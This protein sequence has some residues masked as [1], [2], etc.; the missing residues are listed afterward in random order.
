[1]MT[2][3]GDSQV[4]GT[5]EVVK[6][7]IRSLR[8]GRGIN[9]PSLDQRV[10]RYL[11]EL[12]AHAGDA[13]VGRHALARELSVLAGHLPDDLRTAVASSLGLA[14][15]TKQMAHFDDRVAWLA[16]HLQCGPRTAQ[17]RIDEAEQLLAE[18]TTREL[19]RRRSRTP[20]TADGWYIEEFR[21][22]YR[23]DTAT[24]ES[25]EHRRIVATHDG[26]S[27]VRAW[28]NV[29]GTSEQPRTTVTGE[30]LYGGRLLRREHPSQNRF[31]FVVRL[32]EP[33]R[34][35]QHHEYG[36]ILRPPQGQRLRPHYVF[37]PECDCRMFDLRVRFDPNRLPHW[38]R[39]VDGEPVRVF[40]SAQPPSDRLSPDESGEIHL[41]F[42]RPTMYL[43]YGA[44]WSPLP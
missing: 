2:A 29:P 24:P 25:H 36:L 20:T 12:A 30:V 22:V 21:T 44:Q 15:E 27:E 42:P 31:H 10:G 34:A 26:L 32:P 9:A 8:K 7:E 3:T 13:Y 11:R 33:L 1:M 28:H 38:V 40:D 35:G 4:S 17:R 19:F 23:L 39:R 18:E 41:Q 5:V 37:T 14:P 6:A 16:G 43:G